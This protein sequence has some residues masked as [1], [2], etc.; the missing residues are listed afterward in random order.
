MNHLE[1]FLDNK[2]Y[3]KPLVALLILILA[4]FLGAKIAS[5]VG[6]KEKTETI[7][8]SINVSGEGEVLA[9]P[10]IASV[11]VSVRK[12]DANL[13]AAQNNAA[14]AINKII[15]FLEEEKIQE[16]EERS[17]PLWRKKI[18]KQK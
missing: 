14:D 10:D 6:G 16:K 18:K 13:K 1:K 15:A 9:K 12:E 3:F 17:W 8:S 7:I 5:E 11:S 4:V 2:G